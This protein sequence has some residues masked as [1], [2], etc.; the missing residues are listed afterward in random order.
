MLQA[1]G[2]V[3]VSHDKNSFCAYVFLTFTPLLLDGAVIDCYPS[4]NHT[5]TKNQFLHNAKTMRALHDRQLEEKNQLFLKHI[6][7][8]KSSYLN[9]DLRKD[10][11][12]SRRM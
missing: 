9:E 5:L 4:H 1:G 3:L 2:L 10:Y 6:N 12:E 7:E 8:Q 11:A